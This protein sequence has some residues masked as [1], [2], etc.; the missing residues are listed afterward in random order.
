M[1]RDYSQLSAMERNDLHSRSLNGESLRSIA[2]ILVPSQSPGNSRPSTSAGLSWIE[3]FRSLVGYYVQQI[4]DDTGA[5]ATLGDSGRGSGDMEGYVN[6]R[7]QGIRCP[8]S[9][10]TL[11]A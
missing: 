9:A 1:G 5:G 3:I 2:R 7:L 11:D 8:K 6:A 10:R 4:G